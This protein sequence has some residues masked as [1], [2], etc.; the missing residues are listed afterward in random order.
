MIAVR[1][2]SGRR[3]PAAAPFYVALFAL[4]AAHGCQA[5]E[6]MEIAAAERTSASEGGKPELL[7]PKIVKSSTESSDQRERVEANRAAARIGRRPSRP[8]D[9]VHVRVIGPDGK[10][11]QPVDVPAVSRSDA[12]WQQRLTPAQYRIARGKDTERAF[13]GG[14]L[15]NKKPGMYV[16]ICCDLPLFESGAKF[17]SGTGWPSFFQPAAKENVREES[18]AT[19]G[20]ARTEILCRR[21]DAHLGHV[22]DDGPPPTGRR[23]CLNSE[24]LRFV[25]NEQLK[26]IAQPVPSAVENPDRAEAVFAGGCFWCVEAVFRQLKGV[27]DVTS[28]YAGGTADTANYAAVSTGRTGH[29]ESVRIIYDP[30]KI[31]YE[32][33]LKV[34]FA[35]HD[36]TS[37][38]RQGNDVGP[39][40]RSAVFF[41]DE[42]QKQLAEAMIADLRDAKTFRRPIVTRIEPLTAFYPAEAKHQN[43]VVC[44]VNQPY[45]QAVALPKVEKVREKFKELIKTP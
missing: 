11:S 13:C 45:V 18:D 35:T 19:H 3:G 15:K 44:N 34:H 37:L 39:Q 36:P 14:L 10:L 21:C 28:G 6:G 43:Y 32:T 1:P 12:E 42:H 7:T 23:Y 4:F 22:F 31:S 26:T 29:A 33:L 8:V 41:A 38:N 16:C 25:S 20:M 24:S 5:R 17:E 27:L 9:Y 2:I 30:R 40:Y